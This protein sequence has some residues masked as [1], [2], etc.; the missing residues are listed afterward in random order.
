MTLDI[1]ASMIGSAN[2]NYAV[3]DTRVFAVHTAGG[4]TDLLYFKSAD[5]DGVVEA[6]ELS[7]IVTLGNGAE[8]S[9][10]DLLFGA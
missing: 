5:S 10:S 2:G 1:A 4:A 7:W 3:G 6:S 8:F 9:A